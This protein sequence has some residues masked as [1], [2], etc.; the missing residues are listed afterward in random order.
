[1]YWYGSRLSIEQAR[2]LAPHNNAT[3]LQVAAGIL[4][5]MVWALRHPDA[6]LVE[7]DDLDYEMVLEVASPYL[8]ELVGEYGDWT[9]LQGRSRLF[10]EEMDEEDP[11]QFVNFRVK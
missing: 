7:P 2:E 11:W 8:G 9:P 1:V 5:G 6:G 3:T 10:R 4:A